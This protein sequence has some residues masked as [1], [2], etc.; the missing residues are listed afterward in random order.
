MGSKG[1]V[2]TAWTTQEL[3]G[4]AQKICDAWLTKAPGQGN[5]DGAGLCC[6]IAADVILHA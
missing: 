1:A 4:D 5:Q 6:S 2:Q 3:K